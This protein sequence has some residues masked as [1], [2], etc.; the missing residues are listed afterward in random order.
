VLTVG[1]VRLPRETFEEREKKELA[2]AVLDNP[3][4]LLMY[5]QAE[6][7]VRISLFFH[8]LP[9]PFLTLLCVILAMCHIDGESF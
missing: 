9:S 4:R 7:D 1:G 2:M 3:E 8:L 6:G 5:A